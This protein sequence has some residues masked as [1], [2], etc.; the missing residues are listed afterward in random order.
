L[1]VYL[2]HTA[3]LKPWPA[4]VACLADQLERCYANPSSVHRLGHE[5]EES[6][7][8]SRQKMADALGCRPEEL[9]LTSGGSES[10]N[11]AIKG[12]AA[13]NP[14]LPKRIITSRGEHAAV[15]ESCK[16][17]GGQ[18]YRIDEIP[19]CRD[20]TADLDALA[21]ALGQPAAL[22]SLIHVSNET[23][24]VNPADEIV[25]LRDRLQPLAAIH[26]D[27]VQ[28][29]GKMPFHFMKSRCDLI[30][31]SGHKIGAP[32]GIGWLAVRRGI[33]LEPLIH[34]GGQ[35]KGLR[36]GTENPPLAAAL[37]LAMSLS[38]EDFA[39]KTAHVRQLRQIFLD[40]LSESGIRYFVLSIDSGVPNILS[41]AFP[42]LPGAVMAQAL[43]SR[44][45][46]VS[47]GAACSSRKL[48]SNPVLMAMGIPKDLTDCAIR[49][50]LAS[51]DS[52]MEILEAA[53]AIID[54]CKQFGSTHGTSVI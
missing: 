22:I 20:G 44:G 7:D 2:D 43:E 6:L 30:S 41:A 9:V 4:V 49:I 33:R 25:R 39:G 18:G 46:M 34:G 38:L 12:F 29:F 11:L 24:A 13:A 50:S 16:Y 53:Q 26:L 52:E 3:S 37:A 27:A 48:K 14:R 1:P 28:T 54:I 10:I 23:G 31:G 5:A 8:I 32:K 35:Q 51:T 40:R 42:E 47:T 19:L 36:S 15:R 21:S 17:L 45:I